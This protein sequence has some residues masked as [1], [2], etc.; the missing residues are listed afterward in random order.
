MTFPWLL[1]CGFSITFSALFSKIWRVNQIFQASRNCQR[2]QV[3]ARHVIVPFLVIFSLNLICLTLWT[4]LD[5]LRWERT[6]VD[7]S[8]G[9]GDHRSYGQCSLHGSTLST[10]CFCLILAVNFAAL[11]LAMIQIYRSRNVAERFRQ[12]IRYITVAMAS[13]I[14]VFLTGMPILVIVT[15]NPP[16]SFFVKSSI[17]FVVCMSLVCLTFI[18]KFCTAHTEPERAPSSIVSFGGS[19]DFSDDQASWSKAGGSVSLNSGAKRPMT[20]RRKTFA[21]GSTRM[22]ESAR[23]IMF[24]LDRKEDGSDHSDLSSCN[25]IELAAS[26]DGKVDECSAFEKS[27]S[28]AVMSNRTGGA[29]PMS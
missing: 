11:V 24:E 27:C 3:T 7:D 13:M 29:M 26:N 28:T 15:N 14:Q 8:N 4:A 18:P 5:P 25:A 19:A 20:G 22:Q 21:A 16:V 17:I 9:S 10:I 1:A 2:I 12:E 23:R 6:A